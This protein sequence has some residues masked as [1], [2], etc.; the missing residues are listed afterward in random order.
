V[1]R[2]AKS[3]KAEISLHTSNGNAILQVRDHGIGMPFEKLKQFRSDGT[4]VG[5][6]L[7]GMRERVRE[8]GGTFEIN[9]DGKG[10]EVSVS[11]PAVPVAHARDGEP[12]AS[13]AG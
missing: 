2:H 11:I 6:G 9:S 3:Q 8:H 13:A 12:V 10:T 4:Q 1:H 7:T 5:V